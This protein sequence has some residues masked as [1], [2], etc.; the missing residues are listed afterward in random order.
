MNQTLRGLLVRALRA[1]AGI[2]LLINQRIFHKEYTDWCYTK[3]DWRCTK[4]QS[5]GGGCR[6]KRTNQ[7]GFCINPN[8]QLG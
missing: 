8:A 7:G 4:L 2:L 5:T 3:L 1:R 6:N